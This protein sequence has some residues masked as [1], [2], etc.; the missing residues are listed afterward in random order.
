MKLRSKFLLYSFLSLIIVISSGCGV[1][2]DKKN[3]YSNNDIIVQEADSFSF[4]TRNDAGDSK[5]EVNIKYN[6]FYG[7]DTIW[8][9]EAEADEE[10]ML[11]YNSNVNSGDFKV[12]LI[13]PKKEIE[14]ILEGTQQ[15]DKTI[16]LTKGKYAI[17]IVGRNAKGEIKIAK[18]KK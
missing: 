5:E 2:E 18:S 9:I 13:N 8:I 1:S 11:K 10:I 14:N 6:G 12:V 3:I 16:K 7:A 17:K 4:R 15:G